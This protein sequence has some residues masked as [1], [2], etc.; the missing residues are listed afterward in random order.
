M[1]MLFSLAMITS[2]AFTTRSP[3]ALEQAYPAVRVP[4]QLIWLLAFVLIIVTLYLFPD[5]RFVPRATRLL[6]I[7]AVVLVLSPELPEGMLSLPR[8]QEEMADWHWRAA[9][10]GVLA[11]WCSGL[12]ALRHEAWAVPC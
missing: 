3:S 8:A 6:A 2:I 1:A 10:L 12:A 7:A 4:V 11:L 5:G 9:V